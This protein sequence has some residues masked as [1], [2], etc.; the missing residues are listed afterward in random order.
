MI[1]KGSK[2]KMS[3]N[4][5]DSPGINEPNKKDCPIPPIKRG[6]E[7]MIRPAPLVPGA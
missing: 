3:N 4:G 1:R 5:D 6:I 7:R 2:N